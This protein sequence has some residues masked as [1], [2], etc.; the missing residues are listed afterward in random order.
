MSHD[1]RVLLTT[2]GELSIDGETLLLPV[3]VE[4]HEAARQHLHLAATEAAEP[5]TVEIVD[6][7]RGST[8]L[9]A[10]TPDGTLMDVAPPLITPA[11]PPL[12]TVPD[13]HRTDLDSVIKA[14]LEERHDDAIRQ[15]DALLGQLTTHAGPDHPATLVVAQIRADI[16]WLTA[17]VA[18]AFNAWL[19]IA[20]AWTQHLPN[21]TRAVGVAARNATAVWHHLPLNDAVAAAEELLALLGRVAPHPDNNLTL[22]GV[23]RRLAAAN[24][25][26][27]T[28]QHPPG[29][30]LEKLHNKKAAPA[31]PLI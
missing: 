6:E 26:E 18:Y 14:A 5:I 31:R 19:W 7:T 27:T 22:L 4:P 30:E 17:D 10:I 13:E 21:G 9:V 12:P 25:T 24:N 23:H 15:A 16:A 8:R 3:G 2:S 20:A 1:F 28:K 29:A 11:A